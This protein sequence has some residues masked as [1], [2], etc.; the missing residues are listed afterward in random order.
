M[1]WTKTIRSLINPTTNLPGDQSMTNFRS[2]RVIDCTINADYGIIAAPSQTAALNHIAR[3]M[4]WR[5]YAEYTAA[6]AKH[7]GTRTLIAT[8]VTTAAMAA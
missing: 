4:G 3:K 2:F 8:E 6:A 1:P 5:D 7:S